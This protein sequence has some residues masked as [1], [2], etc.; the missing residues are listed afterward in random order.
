MEDDD[1]EEGLVA[2]KMSRTLARNDVDS[3]ES[4]DSIT[5]DDE[6]AVKTSSS[7]AKRCYFTTSG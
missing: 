6:V 3:H 2:D 4:S 7:F 5:A 1:L